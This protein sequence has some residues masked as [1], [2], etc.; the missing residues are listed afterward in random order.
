MQTT[1]RRIR[2][3]TL[4][5]T[6]LG[7]F[8]VLLD[9]SIIFVALSEIQRDLGAEISHLQWTVDAYTL[10]F[11]ALMLMTGT[12]GDRLGRKRVFL[13]GLVLFIVGSALCGY[14]D[15]FSTLVLGR[16]VQGVGAAAIETASLALLVSTFTDPLGRAKAIGIWTAVSG[17]AL[18]L[19]P[20]LGGVLIESFS[21]HAIFLLNLPVGVLA[22]VLG[23]RWLIESRNP[24][25]SPLDVPGQ[26]L[27]TS[28]LFC[29]IMGLIQGEREGWDSP[30]IIG[31]LVGSVLMLG[32]FI[33]VEKRSREPMFPLELFRN[34][35]FAA[36]GA[37]ASLLGFVIVGAMFFMAQYFQNVQ[38]H[39]ALESGLRLLPLTLGIF[40]LSPLA[41]VVAGRTGPRVPI[42]VGGL[43]VTVGFLLLTTVE[44]GTGFGAVWWKVALV[45]G[46]IGCMFAPLTVAV[47]A[48]TPPERAG[49]GSSVINT[50]RVAGFTAGAAVLGTVVVSQFKDKV[51][52]A[53]SDLGVPAAAGDQIADRV[54]GA[55]AGAGQASDQLRDLPISSADFTAAVNQSF[56]DAIHV[57]FFICAGCT[58]LIA[59]LAYALMTRGRLP[60]PGEGALPG[61]TG[62]KG[63]SPGSALVETGWLAERLGEPGI[64]VVDC[65]VDFRPLPEGGVELG[66][67]REGYGQGHIPGAVFADLLIELSDLTAPKPFGLLPTDRL[68]AA[69]EKLGISNDDTV[70]LYD[71]AHTAFAT[72]LWWLLQSVGHTNATVLNGGWRKWT[73]EGRPVATDAPTAIRGTFVPQPRPELFVTREQVQRAIEDPDVCLINAL[74]P[75]QHAGRIPVAH[76]RTGHIP[77]SVNVPAAS[78]IDPATG[79]FLPHQQLA[80]QLDAVGA[81][82]SGKVIAYCAAGVDAT[83]DAFALK[84]LGVPDVAIYDDGL[85][86]WSGDPSLPLVA[87][88]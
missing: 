62:E 35:T 16:V 19:G 57:A 70:V 80:S 37:I 46:G 55:G 48:S 8:M 52:A 75:D 49:L 20:L 24:D 88:V 78:L 3:L 60:D 82:D 81:K 40:F 45:G 63:T 23:A 85:V 53:L 21:W 76:G 13:T 30:M 72:R 25:A 18:A 22:L 54:G 67:G 15:S 39:S 50:T 14:A 59:V 74:S 79:S 86:E 4:L 41:S 87:T 28:G 31:L 64:V 11:A 7:T 6:S 1:S 84:M 83:L 44:P 2:A 65:T 73:D 66:S 32:G 47:M 17:V 10:P 33:A 27:A 61:G 5:V 43:L 38:E 68:V 9:G 42:I 71:R 77:S 36:S 51:V 69:I 34:R 12:L 58:L 56:V 26:I 29:L